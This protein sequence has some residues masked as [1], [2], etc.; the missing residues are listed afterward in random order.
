MWYTG[1]IQGMQA[2]FSILGM[3]TSFQFPVWYN[4]AKFFDIEYQVYGYVPHN[5]E[6]NLQYKS[7]LWEDSN[8]QSIL[9]VVWDAESNA[10]T[11]IHGLGVRLRQEVI[12]A[13]ISAKKSYEQILPNLKEAIFDSE[14]TK[15]FL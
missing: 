7:Q 3:N 15:K 9:R 11:G 4:S 14:F 12:S 8:K 5:L 2:A 1:K 6:D 10:I 13:W